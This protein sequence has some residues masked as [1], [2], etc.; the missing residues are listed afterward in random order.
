VIGAGSSGITAVKALHERGIP[1]DCFEKSDTVGGLWVINN[2]SGVAAAYSDLC[3]NTSKPRMQ[4]SDF[5]IPD[6]VPEFPH[7]TDLAR[8][9]SRYVDH[10]GFRHKITFETSVERATR[11]DDGVWEVELDNAESRLYDMLLVANGHHWRPR[12]PDPPIAGADTFAGEQLHSHAYR[13][14]S[15][16][17]GKRVVIVGMGNSAMDIVV[18]AS[19]VAAST[20]LVIREGAWIL[21]KYLYGRP[22]DQWPDHPQVPQVFRRTLREVLIRMYVGNPERFGLP[23]PKHKFTHAHG[24][25]SS[26][27]FDRLAH[28][29]ITPKPEIEDLVGSTVRFV[30]GTSI[31]ADIV[32][33]CTGYQIA[34]PFFDEELIAAPENRIALFHRVFHPDFP[35]LAFIGLLQ[36]QGAT[37]P[38]AEAQGSWIGDYLLGRYALPDEKKMRADIAAD[39]AAMRKRYVPSRRH[40]IQVDVNDYLY[41]LAKERRAGAR[42]ARNSPTPVTPRAAPVGAAC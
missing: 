7:H 22:Y 15:I 32:V 28:G 12:W 5:P 29:R 3:I 27:I 31:E 11:R 16:F 34:F 4:Y 20:H 41:R 14:K 8:Y 17:D 42:R 1:F 18:E 39:Q 25:C 23:K 38:L 2:S 10:F 19:Y 40:T 9:F 37:M 13:E 35:N 26:R 6:G 21:P 36:P 30:D 33:Y 24:T